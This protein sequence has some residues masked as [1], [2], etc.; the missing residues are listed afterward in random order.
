MTKVISV[1]D[2]NKRLPGP[3]LAI[4]CIDHLVLTV[5]DMQRTSAFYQ[6]V[7][8]MS[9]QL[10][11]DGRVELKFGRYKINLQQEG[12]SYGP[13]SNFGR[14][15]NGNLCFITKNSMD[16]ILEVLHHRAV[17]IEDGPGYRIGATGRIHSVYVLD[18]EKNLVEISTYQIDS[19]DEPQ[20]P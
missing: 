16:E 3:S 10:L 20:D 4:E 8:G 11:P 14:F 15:W 12:R 6:N 7:L 9:V 19:V 18:P 5:R 17:P 1:H 2:I 13:K